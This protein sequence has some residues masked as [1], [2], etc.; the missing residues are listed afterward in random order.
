[1]NAHE[2]PALGSIEGT[3][4]LHARFVIPKRWEPAAK[5]DKDLEGDSARMTQHGT[6]KNWSGTVP[7]MPQTTAL[8]KLSGYVNG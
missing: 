3:V 5:R 7:K 2:N 6:V 8:A 1:M 4:C